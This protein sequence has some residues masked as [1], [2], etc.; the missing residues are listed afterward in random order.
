MDSWEFNKTAGAVLGTALVVFGLGELRTA[1]YHSPLPAKPGFA[2]QV[3]EKA[4]ETPAGGAEAPKVP[5]GTLLAKA[6]PAKGKDITKAC[7][8]CH[9][10]T[11]G[12]PNK[13]G[14]NL[15]GVVGASAAHQGDFAYSDAMLAEKA[16]GLKW[17]S[18]NLDQF[19][20]APKTFVPDTKMTFAGLPDS[21]D[22]AD[23]I[24]YLRT[25]ADNP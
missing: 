14:P 4:A 22:R 25:L 23:V 11:K 3:A 8:A 10:F 20:T 24:A 7:Q 12:G 19:L 2:I 1:I 21:K 13:V 5:L 17:T 15:W 16:K 18:D 6:D 9:D